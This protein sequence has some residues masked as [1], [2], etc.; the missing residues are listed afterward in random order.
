[1][2]G[3]SAAYE[4]GVACNDGEVWDDRPA[5][6]AQAREWLTSAD[7][8]CGCDELGHHVVRR[9]IPRWEPAPPQS[10]PQESP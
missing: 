5:D 9:V 2:T 3:S 7:V 10:A 8:V 1:M 6:A 4:Y